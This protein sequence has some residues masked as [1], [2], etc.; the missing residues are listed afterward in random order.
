MSKHGI[1]LVW[2]N[3]NRVVDLADGDQRAVHRAHLCVAVCSCGMDH[4]NRF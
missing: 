1:K 4:A 2:I 3:E